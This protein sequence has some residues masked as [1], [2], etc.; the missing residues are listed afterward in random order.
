M[1]SVELDTAFWKGKRVFLT[2][3]T[4]FKGAWL[5]EV[6][7]ALGSTVGGYSLSLPTNP[8]LFEQLGLEQ[9]VD[10]TL[11]DVRDLPALRKSMVGF[12]PD[13]VFHMAAQSLVRY[14]YVDPVGTYSTNVM[15]T[16]HLLEA[17]RLVDSLR[18]VV[19]VTS[20][21]CYE[22][23]EWHWGYRENDS[24][25]GFDPYSS[26]K[27]CAE[28]ATS[29]FRSSFFGDTSNSPQVNGRPD[30]PVGVA[31]VRAGNV[32]GGGDWGS[33]RLI[34]DAIR[35]FLAS[36]PVE[37]RNPGAVRPWQHVLDP[38]RGYLMLAEKL[39]TH[40]A[41]FAESWN[42]GPPYRD[43][44]SVECVMQR[45]CERWPSHAEWTVTKDPQPHEAMNLYLDPSKANSKLSWWPT[46]G[47]EEALDFTCEWYIAYS[48]GE[49]IVKV[50]R[51]QI[52]T[53]LT[54]SKTSENE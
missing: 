29:A 24:L 52:H 25:G 19:V 49:D 21:K 38:L 39:T 1:E 8:S 48:K 30:S 18:A 17:C 37:I 3:H 34:P 44:E 31:S 40:E 9:R 36:R 53:Y 35:A 11:G 13:V 41:G 33:D 7:L 16:V 32:I 45:L 26:S 23:R 22:N 43:A 5:S 47:L 20:D 27:A 6:L 42:F 10:H 54:P 2:G 46:L 15:G 50:T 28:L 51:D 4:G 14:S 12:Q